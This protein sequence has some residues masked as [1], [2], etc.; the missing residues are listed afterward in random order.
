MRRNILGKTTALLTMA[1]MLLMTGCGNGSAGADAD[2]AGSS[3]VSDNGGASESAGETSKNAGTQL[4]NPWRDATEEEVGYITEGYFKIPEGATNVVCSAMDNEGD[5][6]PLYQVT[7]DLDGNNFTARVEYGAEEYADISGM[8]YEW[9]ST[10]EGKLAGW[11][12]GNME[13][14]FYRYVGDECADLCTW[15]DI[16]IGI[17]YSLSTVA[18]DLDGFDIQA[19]AEA[20]YPGDEVLLDDFVQ[21]AAQKETFESFDEVISYLTEGQ[22]Y[23]YLK[24]I[25]HEGDVL[26]VTDY[27]YKNDDK[28]NAS[29]GATLYGEVDGE[30]R[31]LGYV[32]S[33]GTAYPLAA[34]DGLIYGCN[35]HSYEVYFFNPEGT[36]VMLKDNISE[37]YDEAGNASYSGI[38]RKTNNFDDT[39][40][41]TG[42]E[43]EYNKYWENYFNAEVIN[44][45]VVK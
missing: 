23:A 7:F 18:K 25:G 12:D 44:F 15:Y 35:P 4:A 19:V 10:D 36:G 32:G 8:N 2:S 41:F 33:A 26:A 5:E 20:M 43:A 38:T 14:K 42:G 27:V 37:I 30:I 16:E 3:A 29:I 11:G 17:A 13:A 40:E 9:T 34:S 24:V 21:Q 1:A 45:T 28:T 39:V 22:G 31:N 6:K